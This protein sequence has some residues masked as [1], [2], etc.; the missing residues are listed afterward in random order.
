[1]RRGWQPFGK[2][3]GKQ[4][5]PTG[6][7]RR[8]S[9]VRVSRDDAVTDPES[10]TSCHGPGNFEPLPAGASCWIDIATDDDMP[11][12]VRY[13]IPA[14]GWFSFIGAYKDV[15]DGDGDQLVNV[16]V[17]NIE[18]VTVD[19]CN[20][21]QPAQPAVGPTVD[22]LA[23]ALSTLP[24]FEVTSPPMEVTAY[25]YAGVHLQIR[26]PLE[27]AYRDDFESFVGCQQSTLMSWIAPPLSFAFHGYV[28]PGD[29]E[30]FWILDVEGT[31]VAIAA[32][33]TATASNELRAEQR[34]VLDSIEIEP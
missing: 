30:D 20:R 21:Q 6:D 26:I 22:D 7:E 3:A 2:R 4:P 32:L 23:A 12:R 9:D 10:E 28:A 25:G 5:R 13:T 14:A 1:V 24:P 34:A 8:T 27:L 17:A 29:T 15:E 33:A 16:L 18:N 11:V 31:R 19:A